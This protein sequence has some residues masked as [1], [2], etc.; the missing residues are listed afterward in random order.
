[1]KKEE[2]AEFAD[3]LQYFANAFKAHAEDNKKVHAIAEKFFISIAE[4]K[5]SFEWDK[6]EKNETAK[7]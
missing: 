4:W 5:V 6:G 7:A 1:M 3:E 2:I